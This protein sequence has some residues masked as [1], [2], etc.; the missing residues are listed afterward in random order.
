MKEGPLSEAKR[1]L[2][3]V[4]TG[5]KAW[6]KT[7]GK[8]VDTWLDIMADQIDFRSLANGRKGLPWTKTRTGKSEVREYLTGLTAAF[9]M[10]HYT[11][12]QF[13][14]EGDTVVMIG[15]T[16]WHNIKT[17]KLVDTPKV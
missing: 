11:V 13:V 12:D 8:S 4:K 16:A 10:H 9:Q 2:E 15:S 3:K 6:H 1:A 7:K 5:Y 14:C 17:G